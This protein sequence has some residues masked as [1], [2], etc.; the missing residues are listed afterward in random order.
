MSD[1]LEWESVDNTYTIAESNSVPISEAVLYGPV[2]CKECGQDVQLYDFDPDPDGPS[3]S[4]EC[5]E[6][7]LR[8]RAYPT[9]VSLSVSDS[10]L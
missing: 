6:C 5:S 7:D 1:D 8:Y 3:W 9:H 10:T 4:G 2:E